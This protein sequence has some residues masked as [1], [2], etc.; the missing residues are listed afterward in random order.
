MADPIPAETLATSSTAT[1]S[2]E[3][4]PQLLTP[5][6]E[7]DRRQTAG[8]DVRL[9]WCEADRRVLVAVNDHQTGEAFSVEVQGADRALEVFKHPYVYAAWQRKS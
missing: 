2:D 7:L 1:R 6:R 3:M 4:T 5:M 9:L 8:V